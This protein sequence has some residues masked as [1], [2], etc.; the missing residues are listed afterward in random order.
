[1]A[2]WYPEHRDKIETIISNMRDLADPFRQKDYYCYQMEGSYSLKA[3]LPALVNNLS[4]NGMAISDGN[5]AMDAY[6]RMC[7]EKDSAEVEKIRKALLEYCRLDT[8]AMVKI[9][10]KLKNG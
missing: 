5:M 4:Y 3:V 2:E 6:Y 9:L 1:M 10:E 8:L 7:S